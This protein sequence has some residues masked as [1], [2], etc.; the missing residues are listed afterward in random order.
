MAYFVATATYNRHPF[1]I[2]ALPFGAVVD[3]PDNYARFAAYERLEF[4]EQQL[5]Q[6]TSTPTVY[7]QLQL[8]RRIITRIDWPT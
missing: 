3:V 1:A 8:L 6:M 5:A 7:N 2:G 4:A